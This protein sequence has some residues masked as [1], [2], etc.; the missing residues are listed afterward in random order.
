MN[1]LFESVS[2]EAALM[3]AETCCN[4]KP[5]M[6]LKV[7]VNKSTWHQDR[8]FMTHVFTQ[9]PVTDYTQGVMLARGRRDTNKK[10]TIACEEQTFSLCPCTELMQEEF[11]NKEF[12]LYEEL[13]SVMPGL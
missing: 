7:H 4:V 5:N 13:T 2:I 10:W 3:G 11:M 9:C 1:K 12:S 8:S 6:E